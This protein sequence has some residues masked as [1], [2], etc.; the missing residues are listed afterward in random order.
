MLGLRVGVFRV[1]GGGAQ[2]RES[3]AWQL[4]RRYFGWKDRWL[5]W[6]TVER[7][8]RRLHSSSFLWVMFTIL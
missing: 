4:L 8:T 1:K 5:L 6:V 2:G 3:K 7:L